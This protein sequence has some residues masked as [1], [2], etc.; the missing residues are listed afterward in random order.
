VVIRKDQRRIQ[1]D[2]CRSVRRS[3]PSFSLLT[4]TRVSF[5]QGTSACRE[6]VCCLLVLNLV[7]STPPCIRQP[8]PCL[9]ICR[10]FQKSG[11]EMRRSI[12]FPGSGQDSSL[13]SLRKCPPPQEVSSSASTDSEF[14]PAIR[15]RYPGCSL[16]S[17]G[18][19]AAP[20]QLCPQSSV[21]WRLSL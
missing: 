20:V 9:V 13:N 2:V 8:P 12:H 6:T 5:E 11:W 14:W 17:K 1:T 3:S 21:I 15:S 19:S 4:P 7:S 18:L 16:R 10:L